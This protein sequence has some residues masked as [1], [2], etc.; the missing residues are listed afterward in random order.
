MTEKNNLLFEHS[1]WWLLACVVLGLAYA[2]VL[3]HKKNTWSA[4]T[5]K[6]LF[7]IRFVLVSAVAAL[8]L[9]PFLRL[10]L[11]QVEKP[12][13]IIAVDN[14]SSVAQG[15]DSVALQGL[16]KKL[17]VLAETL[18]A[19]DIQVEKR[20]LVNEPA[21]RFEAVSFTEKVTD[22]SALLRNWQTEFEGKPLA[23][24]LVV[25][26]G[27]Y[28]NGMAP[29]YLNFAGKVYTLGIGD[30][31][32]VRD[33]IL[34]N[35]LYNKIA[36]QGNLFPVRAEI[37]SQGITSGTVEVSVSRGGKVVG[38]TS[39]ALSDASQ[40]I[41]A[42]F[43]IPAEEK[44][45]Q[46]YVVRVSQHPDEAI[47]VNNSQDI[48]IDIVE[49]REKIL[50]ASA[51][52]HPDIKALKVALSKN[53]NYEVV[54]Y[55][56]SVDKTMPTEVFD[57]VVLISPFD[58]QRRLAPLL[59]RVA[60]ENMSSWLILG[61]ATNW[62]EASSNS[63]LFSV[64]RTR[65]ESDQVRPAFNEAFQLFTFE[66]EWKGIVNSYYTPVTVPYGD[67]Q[68]QGGVT[69]AL[70]QKVGAITTPRPLWLFS[71]NQLPKQAVTLG[72]GLWQW[73]MQ[74]FSRTD[75]YQAFDNLV[76]KTV[77][78]L[79]S[80]EDKRKFR[81]YTSKSEFFDNEQVVFQTEAYND[82]FEPVFGQEVEL[83][84]THGD[85]SVTS[86]NYTTAPGNTRFRISGLKDGIYKFEAGTS[87]AGRREVASGQF[88]IRK[89]DLEN[90]RLTADFNTLREL[91]RAT[92]G[93]FYQS[94]QW[95]RL[96]SD[97]SG[98]EPRGK[99][100][101]S[102]DYLPIIHLWWI[103]AILL[104]LLSTEWFIRKYSGSY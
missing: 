78:Y 77:Q 13:F 1:P 86:Y 71:Q 79:S 75:S 89:M 44:G 72:E 70:Y 83:K 74:E 30:T 42:D 18:A 6:V 60:R 29:Q 64:E 90:L 32:P 93:R 35:L 59:E 33:I 25:S 20:T 21:G 58:R 37:V 41:N 23:G 94:N 76:L 101:S 46:H 45:L 4:A 88:T 57:L 82:V 47:T 96:S 16:L 38:N 84:I 48:Y 61:D 92:G 65:N 15:T 9:S 8:L 51:A 68:I 50:I 24:V 103:F 81:V 98:M 12:A 31:I 55:V 28:N 49:G 97:L 66:D 19:K 62:A 43:Q 102:E 73:R 69:V 104:G 36:Y 2:F 53:E 7:T 40:L 91:S 39:I 87:L 54:T 3:Y 63:Q 99:I 5:N 100:Y 17:D 22:L 85:G 56:P 52:P 95:D 11:N 80:K 27:I 26:D 10:V 34:N 14:S 67:Y